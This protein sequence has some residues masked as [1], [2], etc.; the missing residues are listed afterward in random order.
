MLQE[1]KIPTETNEEVK[2]SDE[3]RID[4][5]RTIRNDL[6]KDFLDE[7]NLIA[8]FSEQYNLKELNSRRIEFIKKELKELLIAPIDL[9]HYASLLLEMKQNGTASL[10]GKNE[11]LFYD[12]LDEIFNR[13]TF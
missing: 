8:Y 13:Y 9:A 1:D 7:K 4:I 6:I 10:S 12:E 3:H 5:I 2:L 11:K